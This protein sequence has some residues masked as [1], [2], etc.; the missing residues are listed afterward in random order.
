VP[1]RNFLQVG[2]SPEETVEFRI[3][4]QPAQKNAYEEVPAYGR[5]QQS[6]GLR[7]SFSH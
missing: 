7:F 5:T 3:S 2:L 4:T 6:N 1:E